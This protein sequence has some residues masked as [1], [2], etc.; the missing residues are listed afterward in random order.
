MPDKDDWIQRFIRKGLLTPEQADQV[1]GME[2]APSEVTRVEETFGSTPTRGEP[3][4]DSPQLVACAP[5]GKVFPAP[6]LDASRP[7]ACPAC[8]GSTRLVELG[9]RLLP[10]SPQTPAPEERRFGRYALRREL[11][12]GGMGVVHE[13]WDSK[14]GRPVAL[15]MLSAPGKELDEEAVERLM[16]EARAAAKLHHPGIVA[17]HDIGRA[18]G[19]HYFTMELIS[20]G[21]LEQRFSGEKSWAGFPQRRRLEVV[22]AVAEALG[23]A[24]SQGIVHR[25]IKPSNILFDPDGRPKLTD[26]GLAKELSP[27]G[28]G[29]LTMTGVVMGT[30]H[31]MSPEQASGESRDITPASD[32]FSL[33]VVLYRAISGR[34][35]FGG[36]GLEALHAAMYSHPSRPTRRG[37]RTPVALQAVCLKCLEKDPA[38]RY[39][40]G[41][42]LA[43]ELRRVIAGVKVEARLP[44]RR[45]LPARFG[46][47]AP[48]R[49]PARAS[50]SG[51]LRLLELGRPA[52]DR[53]C[54]A[55]YDNDAD[56]AE[57]A[58]RLE[59]ARNCFR[60]ALD[61][62]PRLPLAH[63]LLGQTHDLSGD[64]AAAELC[65]R[66]TL[67]LDPAFGPAHFQLGRLLF[68]RAFAV[69]VRFRYEPPNLR[70]DRLR[71]AQAVAG[72]ATRSFD[73]ALA[74]GSG[75]DDALHQ[76]VALAL[77]AMIKEDVSGARAACEE[78]LREFARSEGRE[79]FHW[80]LGLTSKGEEALRHLDQALEIRP[81]F[82]RALFARGLR[83]RDL[84]DDPG[85]LED[86]RGVVRFLPRFA[87]GWFC[88]GTRCLLSG[89]ASEAVSCFQKGLAIGSSHP[90]I[91]ANLSLARLDMGDVPAALAD[92][93]RALECNP[94]DPY[95]W[96]SRAKALIRLGRPAEARPDL[97]EAWKLGPGDAE[98]CNEI[99]RAMS[100][101]GDSEGAIS[102]LTECIRLNPQHSISWNNRGSV[103]M[104]FMGDASGA[105]DDFEAA[106]RID[107]RYVNALS[108]LSYARLELGDATGAERD[109]S[110]AIRLSPKY[111]KPWRRRAEARV[112]QGR[113]EEAL[114]DVEEALRLTVD[115][116]RAW[117]TSGEAKLLLGR[118]AES[119]SD[120]DRAVEMLPLEASSWRLRGTVR[121]ALG[122]QAGAIEDHRK[123]LELAPL[124]SPDR[125]MAESY[126]REAGRAT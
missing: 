38:D 77:T 122:D 31:Y 106:L 34:L 72:E 32:V 86:M 104:D 110:E 37:A 48:Q 42:A 21:S 85:A 40:D 47:R 49:V 53:A 126:L 61:K 68:A 75:F 14:L 63:Y 64:D 13:A 65:W 62:A 71:E 30:P 58:R 45:V 81:R 16:R 100:A 114:A 44:K 41:C 113:F 69:S 54:K 108:N 74:K 18:E 78:G 105:R 52:L 28:A 124:G 3:G 82:G 91:W 112:R 84:G 111:G 107:P 20:G 67:K 8:G 120:L 17:V 99:G 125:V 87:T 59:S 94:A 39:S 1:A 6:G 7:P 102:V 101:A 11:G 10:S 56:D 116:G 25:D 46:R 103:R 50:E 9:G 33:G 97:R 26:F 90:Q 95:A 4:S 88:L 5:C 19:R 27:L 93:A 83:R 66:E 35:P 15:K 23:Y 70:Q 115:D 118:L 57:I 109:A 73:A 55:V 96:I 76:K 123:V 119:R 92:A 22:L 89:L 36:E 51:A 24:H 79:E 43:S 29:S 2:R 12:R 117:R 121:A 80:L 98:F 60:L